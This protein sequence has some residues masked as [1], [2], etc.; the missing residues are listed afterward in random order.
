MKVVKGNLIIFKKG[1]HNEK[2]IV[3]QTGTDNGVNLDLHDDGNLCLKDEDDNVVW[4][5]DMYMD[6]EKV[7]AS[8]LTCVLSNLGTLGAY[9]DG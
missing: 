6:A 9:L 3:W 1:Q 7:D 5:S 2:F 8:K 4:S